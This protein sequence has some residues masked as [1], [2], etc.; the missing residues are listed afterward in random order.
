[1]PIQNG[2]GQGGGNGSVWWS[3]EYRDPKTQARRRPRH[4]KRTADRRIPQREEVM[5]DDL[6]EGHD[7]TPFD[8]IGV[9]D[10]PGCFRVQLRFRFQ[11]RDKIPAK[12]WAV[13]EQFGHK[14]E[15]HQSW[16]LELDV[17]AIRRDPPA[18]EE[19]WPDMPWEIV[20]GW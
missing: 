12:T 8:Q 11:D 6:V 2:S 17:P 20:W 1:M 18:R 3:I 13:V 14:S 7:S 10:H 9:P 5:V 16:F 15:K 19:G 4:E